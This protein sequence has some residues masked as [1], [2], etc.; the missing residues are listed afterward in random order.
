MRNFMNNLRNRFV[1]FMYGRYGLDQMGRFMSNT[2]MVM[3]VISLV[4]SLLFGGTLIG[5]VLYYAS[6]ILLIWMYFRM[7]SKNI[8]KRQLENTKFLELQRKYG[9]TFAKKW[10]HLK[11][12]KT[13]VFFKCP[14]CKLKMRTPKG[15]GEKH[16][17]C[18]KCGTQFTKRT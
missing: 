9:G 14:S 6:L 15:Q 4:L 8:Y 12:R 1:R 18:P 17:T 13:H 11:Q 5:Q 10:A 2:L 3:L 7:F 16:V